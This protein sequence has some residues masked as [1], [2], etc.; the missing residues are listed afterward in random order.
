MELAQAAGFEGDQSRRNMRRRREAAGV[1]NANLTALARPGGLHCFHVER[2]LILGS[3]RCSANFCLVLLKGLGQATRKDVEWRPRRFGEDTLI[4]ACILCQYLGRYV[5]N[6]LREKHRSIFGEVAL[7]KDQ[8]KLSSIGS[9]PLNGMRKACG[10][11]PKIAFS[12]VTD[13]HGAIGIHDRDTGVPIEHVSPF[14]S[15]VPV[16]LAIAARSESH[17]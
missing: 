12:N 6:G 4:Q 14:V 1:N 16:C 3:D 9:K 15:G 5:G 7:V 8:E 10:K 13:K 2:V 17:I 11:E